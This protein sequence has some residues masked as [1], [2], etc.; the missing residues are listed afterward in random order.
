MNF[1][2]E[3]IREDLNDVYFHKSIKI[4]WDIQSKSS[5]ILLLKTYCKVII[6]NDF[7]VIKMNA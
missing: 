6:E 5:K 4:F 7:N 2:D 1:E 3:G